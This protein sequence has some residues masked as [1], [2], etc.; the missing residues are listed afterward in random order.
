MG[1]RSC[2]EGCGSKSYDHSTRPPS[3]RVDLFILRTTGT[4]GHGERLPELGEDGP[5]ATSQTRHY[6]PIQSR[7]A[8]DW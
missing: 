4:K 6:R 7:A 3:R 5:S 8:R 2:G 1:V